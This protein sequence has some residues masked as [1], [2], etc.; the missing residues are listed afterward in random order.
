MQSTGTNPSTTKYS[1]SHRVQDTLRIGARD[2]LVEHVKAACF[3][4]VSSSLAVLPTITRVALGRPNHLLNL[5]ARQI[6]QDG[7]VNS[8]TLTDHGLTGLGTVIGLSDTGID[9]R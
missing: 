8:E 7:P 4:F 3:A 9:E 6:M 2:V 1:T 5:Y